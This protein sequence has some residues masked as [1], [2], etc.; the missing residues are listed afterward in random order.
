MTNILVDADACPVKPEIYRVARRYGLTV[1]LVA[2]SW[3]RIPNGEWLK[4]QVV[5]EGM[6]AAD[7]WIVEHAAEGDIVITADILLADRC[8]Q[9][10]TKVIGV[11]GNQFT[12]EN[13]GQAKA[14]RNLFEDLRSAGEKTSGPPPLTNRDKSQFLQKLDE[15]IQ[16]IRR[17]E[18]D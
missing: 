8:L 4:L 1:I 2:D 10:G 5:K 17:L 11:T 7:D 14:M 3:M 13:I 9:K 12:A 18:Q 16:K 15:V 6:D